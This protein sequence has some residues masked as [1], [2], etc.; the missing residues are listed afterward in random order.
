LCEESKYRSYGTAP[1]LICVF[2]CFSLMLNNYMLA[3]SIV[4]DAEK[5]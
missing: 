2:V 1:V 5:L 3:Y 4:R